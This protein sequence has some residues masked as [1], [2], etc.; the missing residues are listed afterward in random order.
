MKG[1]DHTQSIPQHSNPMMDEVKVCGFQWAL[2]P[3]AYWSNYKTMKAYF[4]NILVPWF[5]RAKTTLELPANQP[6]IVIL[7]AWSLHRSLQ[8]CTW[9]ADTPAA[10]SIGTPMNPGSCQH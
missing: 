8:F 6:C 4:D 5:T 1:K 3:D 10:R 9:V 2:N 7:D